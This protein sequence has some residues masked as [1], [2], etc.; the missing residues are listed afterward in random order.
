MPKDTSSLNVFSLQPIR[1]R[2]N[3]GHEQKQVGQRWEWNGQF[4]VLEMANKWKGFLSLKEI[5]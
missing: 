2:T 5:F 3:G 1:Q 4:C